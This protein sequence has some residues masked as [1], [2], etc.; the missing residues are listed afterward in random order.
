[1]F[2]GCSEIRIIVIIK[3][4]QDII[5]IWAVYLSPGTGVVLINFSVPTGGRG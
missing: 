1:M 5:I 2:V 3:Y 4:V